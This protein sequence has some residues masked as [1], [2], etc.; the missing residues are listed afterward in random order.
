MTAWNVGDKEWVRQRKQAWK[1]IKP[2]VDQLT[3]LDREQRQVLKDYYLSGYEGEELP[4]MPPLSAL[5][6][7][8]DILALLPNE[9]IRPS[10]QDMEAAPL[11]EMWLCPDHSNE[12]WESIKGKYEDWQWSDARF[13]FKAINRGLRFAPG[14]ASFFDGLEERMFYFLWPGRMRRSDWPNI[15]DEEFLKL[16]G[17]SIRLVQDFVSYFMDEQ[18]S[19]FDVI[20]YRICEWRDALDVA[21]QPHPHLK[22]LMAWIKRIL[23]SPSEYDEVK[24]KM[25]KQ[26]DAVLR[27]PDLLPEVKEHFDKVKKQAGLSE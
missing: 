13:R 15:S 23:D 19:P 9:K 14:G 2:K 12:F 11:L 5:N 10:L 21:F 17:K 16:A 26:L 3:F 4:V 27:D 24:L 7:L 1:D 22:H 20:Q 6:T 25:A 8:D 18:A